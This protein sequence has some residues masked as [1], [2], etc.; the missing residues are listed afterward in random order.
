MTGSDAMWAMWTQQTGVLT[1]AEKLDW[2]VAFRTIAKAD[3]EALKLIVVAGIV[4]LRHPDIRAAWTAIAM[5]LAATE[6]DGPPDPLDADRRLALA[7]LLVARRCGDGSCRWRIGD[8]LADE[9]P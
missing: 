2:R 4:H 5:A 3:A 1:D 7:I 6:A 8:V 9:Q